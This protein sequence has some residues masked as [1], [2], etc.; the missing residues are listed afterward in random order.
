M[1]LTSGWVQ[2]LSA[3]QHEATFEVRGKETYTT[4]F[5][6][7]SGW[8]CTCPARKHLCAHVLACMLVYPHE[9]PERPS[10]VGNDPEIDAL[11]G[12]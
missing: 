1:Y 3:N 9:E 11:L 7:D 5:S 8:H 10:L 4:G 2:V 6:V 12:G